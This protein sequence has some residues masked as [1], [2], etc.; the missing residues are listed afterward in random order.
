MLHDV[1][2]GVRQIRRHPG[3]AGAVILTLA[4]GVGAT[5]A[6]F[7][8]ADPMLFRPLP[9]PDADR[10]VTDHVTGKDVFFLQIADYLRAEQQHG[11][12][13]SMGGFW[14][15][16]MGRVSG[17]DNSTLAYMV[18]PGMLD[19]LGVQ[20]VVGRR[21]LRD[22]YRTPPQQP[23]VVMISFGLWQAAFGGRPDVLGRSL[24]LAGR[25]ARSYRIVGVLPPGFMLPQTDN[26]APGFLLPGLHDRTQEANPYRGAAIYA[27]LKRGT[28]LARASA[29]LQAVAAGVER[30][31][32]TVPRSR[33]VTLEPLQEA[34][35]GR[36]HTPL[37]MLLAATGC[38]LVLA[39]ANLAHLFMARLRARQ[40]ELGIRLAVG[41]G[42]GRLVR[43]LGVEA[44]MLAAVGGLGALL[45]AQW[46]FDVIMARTP[47][48]AHIY[49][50]LA[51][52]MDWR[53]A[54]F[55][56][57]LVAFALVIFGL[58]PTFV[59]SRADILG[60]LRKGGSTAS[61][62][63]LLPRDAVLILVQSAV[64]VTLIVT[65]ALI[66]RS[67]VRLVYQPLGYAPE[68]VQWI[69][70]ELPGL[71]YADADLARERQM[72]RAIYEHL[73]VTVPLPVTLAG[74]IPGLTLPGSV[75]VPSREGP[76]L[77]AVAYPTAGTFFE[78]FGVTLLRGRLFTDREA[79]SGVPVCVV[80]Q[81][82][83]ETLWPGEDAIGKQVQDAEGT[84]HTVVGIVGTL[85]KSLT[86]HARNTGSVFVSFGPKARP[87]SLAFR[88]DGTK[89][90]LSQ[91][92]DAVH[93]VAPGA[94]V[95][96]APLRVFERT[97]GQPRFL[98]ALLGTLGLLTLALTTVGIF[99]VVNHEVVRRTQEVGVRMSLGAS[100]SRIRGMV[101]RRVLLPAAAG[102]AMGTGV[103]LWWTRTLRSLLFQLD[104]HD[105]ITFAL[106][107]ALVVALVATAGL[108]P[109]WRASR[110]DP[111]VAL[112][113]E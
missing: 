26:R 84:L 51:A 30:D 25:D 92:R 109:A 22:E 73:Q 99:G 36:V 45:V 43:Q 66:V 64:A 62:R 11:G 104:P 61:T 79:L 101:L 52:R 82:A 69:G 93:E 102:A 91:I 87:P 48:F 54:A 53:V 42:T 74:G 89:V 111:T 32:P 50:L 8:L 38:V 108:V 21:F 7:T 10:I 39:C 67:Y 12:F 106:A 76:P 110:V 98:A 28:S 107:A 44:A 63:R 14:P 85:R 37:L 41:A 31:F 24:E 80:D 112:R 113:A 19:V 58:I 100:P 68:R 65:S 96:V 27:K 18:T 34:L 9:Y 6:V 2:A 20:P 97:L 33:I 90:T 95:E 59:A 75:S 40:R 46:T 57:I 4:L 83:A 78:V 94:H 3:Y 77:A 13:E 1:R 71:G 72:V 105:P 86:D 103:S 81:R 88:A 5:S 60:S 47:T 17:M 56:G 29:E 16:V 49:R 23:D 70:V 55:A 35:F 15:S